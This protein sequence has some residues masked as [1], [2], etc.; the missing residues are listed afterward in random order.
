MFS[1]D[2][3]AANGGRALGHFD[4][5]PFAV[6]VRAPAAGFE[7]RGKESIALRTAPVGRRCPGS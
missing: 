5:P 2:R 4:R 6:A 3:M 7:M 1:G